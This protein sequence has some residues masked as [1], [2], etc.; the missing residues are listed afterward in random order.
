MSQLR[1]VLSILCCTIVIGV[2]CEDNVVDYV[3]KFMVHNLR[4]RR[5]TLILDSPDK[6]STKSNQIAHGI[7]E[8][9]PCLVIDVKLLKS[10]ESEDRDVVNTRS[11]IS[12]RLEHNAIKILI[13]DNVGK[14]VK[15]RNDDQLINQ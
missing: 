10:N 13:I 3:T 2:T 11:L 8:M 4:S 7:L 9:L 15:R 5:I 6:V 14:I 12:R 1:R